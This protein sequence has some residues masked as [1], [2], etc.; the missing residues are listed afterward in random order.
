MTRER[1]EKTRKRLIREYKSKLIEKTSRYCPDSEMPVV[2]T[3]GEYERISFGSRQ[4][5]RQ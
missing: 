2:V 5:G 4:K 3:G 1:F